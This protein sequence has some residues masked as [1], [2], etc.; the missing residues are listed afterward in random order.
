MPCGATAGV[1]L[2]EQLGVELAPGARRWSG[3][4][5]PCQRV[6]VGLP[7]GLSCTSCAASLRSQPWSKRRREW[8]R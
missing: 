8:A 5:L 4:E 3:M 6:A 7:Q 1:G 2:A